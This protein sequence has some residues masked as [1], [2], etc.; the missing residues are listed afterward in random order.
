MD[1]ASNKSSVKKKLSK[2]TIPV[3]TV[4]EPI[5]PTEEQ[6][7][8]KIRPKRA[9]SKYH[10]NRSIDETQAKQDGEQPTVTVHVTSQLDK[11]HVLL[12]RRIPF[13]TR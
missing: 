6:Q 11:R 3:E 10:S 4:D 8:K 13:W 1:S 9:R 12:H 5:V 2:P 7:E